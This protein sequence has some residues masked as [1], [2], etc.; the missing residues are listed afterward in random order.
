MT[1][2]RKRRL[3]EPRT[4]PLPPE[5]HQPSKAEL[6]EEVDMPKLTK[7]QLRKTFLRA[8]RVE[9]KEESQ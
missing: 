6:E 7:A 5:G 1:K 3:Q 9:R 2:R 4:L 8:F